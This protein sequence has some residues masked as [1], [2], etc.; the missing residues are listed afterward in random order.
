MNSDTGE[1]VLVD[2]FTE[3]KIQT[4]VINITSQT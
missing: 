4:H 3:N 1:E 2:F